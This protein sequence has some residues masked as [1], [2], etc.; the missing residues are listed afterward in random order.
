MAQHALHALG[1]LEFSSIGKGIESADQMVKAADVT[2]LFFRT[3]CPGKFIAAVRGETAAVHASVSA[4]LAMG[5][6][7][8]VDW[9]TLANIHPEVLAALAGNAADAGES[10]LGILE[11][12][13]AASIVLASDAAV[14]A[15]DVRL[16][17]V[18]IAMGLGGKGYA[19]MSGDVAAVQAAVQTGAR[20]AS[21]AGLLVEQTVIPSPAR[22]V[23]EQ[24]L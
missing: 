10:A 23:W 3:I 11:T 24:I 4:G 19:L 16:L 5:G 15:A 8:V 20:S 13:S 18:R 9:F 7:L 2:P 17:D 12:F 22:T 1:M 14:K 21:D 6:A